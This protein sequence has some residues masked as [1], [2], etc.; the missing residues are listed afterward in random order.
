MS[1]R[2]KARK[3]ALDVLFEAD[4]RAL[5]PLDVLALRQAA[6]D[7]PVA[8]YAAT[9][10]TGVSAHREALDHELASA[11]A[12][13]WTL[14]RLPAVDRSLL[15]IGLFELRFS[16]EVPSGVAISEA[17]ELAAD[18]STDDSPSYINAV[19]AGLAKGDTP[20]SVHPADVPAGR[21]AAAAIAATAELSGT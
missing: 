19:L 2:R 7:P 3:R 10:V 8:A 15:R 6:A 9:L 4:Q 17:V 5:D 1:A 13:N 11:L 12:G 21:A 20:P 18:L 14:D 16:T